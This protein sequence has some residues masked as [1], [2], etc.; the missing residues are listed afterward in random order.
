MF[1]FR[2]KKIYIP[3]ANVFAPL[4]IY[5]NKNYIKSN[6][7]C[8]NDTNLNICILNKENIHTKYTSK[9]NNQRIKKLKKLIGTNNFNDAFF[10]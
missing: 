6:S 4:S 5:I 8:D 2:I 3:K 10:K 7:L 1:H 9:I